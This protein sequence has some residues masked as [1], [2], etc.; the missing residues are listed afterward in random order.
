MIIRYTSANIKNYVKKNDNLTI[1]NKIH[2]RS[3]VKMSIL[4]KKEAFICSRLCPFFQT[5]TILKTKYY[6]SSEHLSPVHC[7]IHIKVKIIQL[8]DPSFP[9]AARG[10]R[11][12]P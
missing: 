5:R 10:I 8:R 1:L 6:L 12:T 9:P 11:P 4:H 2:A 7:I 3:T